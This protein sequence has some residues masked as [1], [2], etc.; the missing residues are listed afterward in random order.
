MSKTE[1]W[2]RLLASPFARALL[3]LFFIFV[4]GL[5]FNA[6]GTFFRWDTHRDMLRQIST[7]GIL[8]SGLTIVIVSGGID[9]SVGS[10]LGLTAVT[11]S[12]LTIHFGW[13]ATLATFASLGLGLSC[14]ALAGAVI[15]GFGEREFACCLLPSFVVSVRGRRRD[16]SKRVRKPAGESA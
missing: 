12:L 14:G 6:D 5:I 15:G 3:S 8:A 16:P 1:S 13:P 10:V 11:F 4:L 2:R 9:L 7:Y